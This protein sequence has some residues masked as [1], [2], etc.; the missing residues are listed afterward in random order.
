MLPSATG[1]IDPTEALK[2]FKEALGQVNQA[3]TEEFGPA[4]QAVAQITQIE[5]GLTAGVRGLPQAL[6]I[7][8]L[9]AF[10]ASLATA[11]FQS[12]LS[13]LGA[14]R[15]QL[16]DL[17][18]R[19]MG[20]DLEAVQ[21]FPQ[22]AQSVL[23]IGRDVGAS[24]PLFASLFTEVNRMLQDVLGQQRDI[25]ADILKDIDVSILEASRDQIAELRA[26]FAAMVEQLAGLRTEI[27]KLQAAA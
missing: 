21:A 26:G 22:L 3:L 24:G 8:G 5:A 18:S 23:S 14:A 9:E 1:I 13:R 4:L 7:T 16:S 10:Q 2:Q 12:P 20:G 11:D 25:Q 19:A 27:R 15:S 6:G 17:F